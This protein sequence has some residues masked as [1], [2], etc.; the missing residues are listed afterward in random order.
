M[1]HVTKSNEE[2]V[3]SFL[4]GQHRQIE[5]LFK[6]VV[7]R[8]GADR[9]EK[10]RDLCHLLTIHEAGE[11]AVVHPVASRALKHGETVVA[12]RLKEESAAMTT[13]VELKVLDPSSDEFDTKLRKLQTSVLAHAGREER[14][15]LNK[16]AKSIDRDRL[17]RMRKAVEMVESRASSD[18]QETDPGVYERV[19]LVSPRDWATGG[20]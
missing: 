18:A 8:V 7:A 2:D 9:V 14:E 17:L 19:T 6:E 5:A 20:P 12:A 10:F 13:I 11:E 4:K 15:E 1:G 3:V 16:L